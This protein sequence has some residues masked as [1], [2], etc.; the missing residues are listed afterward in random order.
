VVAE[1]R[2]TAPQPLAE[3][4]PIAANSKLGIHIPQVT[5]DT[6]VIASIVPEAEQNE[7]VFRRGVKNA[8][9]RLARLEVD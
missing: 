3:P 8:Q 7:R 9:E 1:L 4:Q 6:F 2:A 5:R